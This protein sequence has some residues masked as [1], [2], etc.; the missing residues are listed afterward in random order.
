MQVEEKDLGAR[1]PRELFDMIEEVQPHTG[2][3]RPATAAER[4]GGT[5]EGVY[6]VT[7][8]PLLRSMPLWSWDKLIAFAKVC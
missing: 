5:A 8:S 1:T 7:N 4:T 2:A 3:L 6:K